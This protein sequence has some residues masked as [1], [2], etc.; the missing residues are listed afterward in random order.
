MRCCCFALS[1][2]DIAFHVQ[3]VYAERLLDLLDPKRQYIR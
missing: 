3:Q 1:K 2:V